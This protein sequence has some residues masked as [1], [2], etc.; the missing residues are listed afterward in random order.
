MKLH[1]NE[2]SKKIDLSMENFIF[3][4]NHGYKLNL[5]N[6]IYSISESKQ[7]T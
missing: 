7:L 6:N 3:H 2:I 1:E 5:E 4:E